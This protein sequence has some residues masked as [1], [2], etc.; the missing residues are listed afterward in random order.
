MVNGAWVCF[1][2]QTSDREY[3]RQFN[4][5]VLGLPLTVLMDMDYTVGGSLVSRRFVGGSANRRRFFGGHQLGA[6]T[7]RGERFRGV[8]PELVAAERRFS[9][10]VDSGFDHITELGGGFAINGDIPETGIVNIA[11]LVAGLVYLLGPILSES[12]AAREKEITTDIADAI[13]KFEEATARL[14]EAEKSQAQAD[15]VVAEINASISKDQA[16]Y[17]ANMKAA[18]QATMERQ[19]AAADRALEEMK[20]GAEQRVENFIQSA[21]VSRGLAEMANLKPDQQKK[22]MDNAISSL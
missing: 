4:F 1:S 18:A 20:S 5:A 15:Q 12:M 7:T 17:E 10:A 14:A 11:I 13:A 2:G 9:S 3:H 16:E 21:A 8:H 19:A 6:G 22:F